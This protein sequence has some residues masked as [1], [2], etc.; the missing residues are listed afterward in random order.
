MTRDSIPVAIGARSF[1]SVDFY[2][3]QD[4]LA[5]KQQVQMQKPAAS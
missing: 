2:Q 3:I 1:I 5:D 4:K